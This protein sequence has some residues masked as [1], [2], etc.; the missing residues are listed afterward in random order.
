MFIKRDRWLT[1]VRSVDDLQTRILKAEIE[2][3]G[4]H[5]RHVSEDHA[6][7]P[8]CEKC[9]QTVKPEPTATETQQQAAHQASGWPPFSH[10]YYSAYFPTFLGGWPFYR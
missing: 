1:L 9:G 5:S 6:K 3:I 2:L 10:P 4:I 8:K 7:L